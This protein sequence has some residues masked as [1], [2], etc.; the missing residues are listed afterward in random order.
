VENRRVEADFGGGA[1]TSDA[2]AL[3]LGATDRAIGLIDRFAA[4]FRDG[5]SAPRVE[6]SVATMVGQRVFGLAAPP[7][8]TLPLRRKKNVHVD[9]QGTRRRHH[10]H[11]VH[12]PDL[13]GLWHGLCH[14]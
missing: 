2:G 8:E 10:G 13:L 5:R 9:R 3:L 1:M 7:Q 4:C 11:P 12:R 6:H 14:A